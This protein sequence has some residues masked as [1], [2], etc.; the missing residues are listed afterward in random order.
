MEAITSRSVE[1]DQ[2]HSRTAISATDAMGIVEAQGAVALHNFVPYSLV[3]EIERELREAV[4]ITDYT[5]DGA[6]V[7]RNQD[8]AHYGF[9]HNKSWLTTIEGLDRPPKYMHDSAQHVANFVNSGIAR[10]D[11]EDIAFWNPNEIIGHNYNVGQFIDP[12]RDSLRA[13]GFV[14]VETVFGSQVFN[15]RLDGGEVATIQTKPRTLTLL[16]GYQGKNGRPRPEHWV[17]KATE[18]RIAISI[19]EWVTIPPR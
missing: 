13:I 18:Q 9:S 4:M 5:P 11:D 6:K 3:Y 7:E 1:F 8:L 16:R 2:S 15:V 10:Y 14:A 19:R 17:D 12:H